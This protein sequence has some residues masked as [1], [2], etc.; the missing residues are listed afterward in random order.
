MGVFRFNDCEH[1]VQRGQKVGRIER[2]FFLRRVYKKSSQDGGDETQ[3]QIS[4]TISSV[5]KQMPEA[6]KTFPRCVIEN[7][8]I[9]VC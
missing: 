9:R 8:R 4:R 2:I 6:L 7:M 1:I 5:L 3:G